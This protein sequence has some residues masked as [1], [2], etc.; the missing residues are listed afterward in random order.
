MNFLK[1][2]KIKVDDPWTGEYIGAGI[3]ERN[4]D[5]AVDRVRYSGWQ[6]KAGDIKPFGYR[7]S[8]RRG[9]AIADPIRPA[10]PARHGKGKATLNGAH[11]TQLPSAYKSVCQTP[12][13]SMAS[14]RC[15]L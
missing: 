7:M 10:G 14:T 5:P 8:T 3:P 2:R 1:S 6:D 15:S 4:I 9:L 13:F 11:S 12:G